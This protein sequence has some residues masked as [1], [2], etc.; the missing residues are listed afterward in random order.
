MHNIDT[1]I[2]ARWAGAMLCTHNVTIHNK[3]ICQ[4][5]AITTIHLGDNILLLTPHKSII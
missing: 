1:R 3:G 4:P 2:V 5:P